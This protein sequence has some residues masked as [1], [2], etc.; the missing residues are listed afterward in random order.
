MIVAANKVDIMQ[1]PELLQRLREHVQAQ[2]L[3]SLRSPPPPTR[4]PGS[5]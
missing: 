3:S 1:D 2:G 4:A 5:W